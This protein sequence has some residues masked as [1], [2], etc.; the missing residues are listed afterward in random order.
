MREKSWMVHWR[1]GPLHGKAGK[2]PETPEIAPP[3]AMTRFARPSAVKK[4]KRRKAPPR[5]TEGPVPFCGRVWAEWW[6]GLI[7]ALGYG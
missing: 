2:R 1:G 5:R 4:P 6:G 7:K 3:S